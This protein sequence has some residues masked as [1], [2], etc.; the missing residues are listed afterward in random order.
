M[1]PIP[2]HLAIA[3]SSLLL[4]AATACGGSDAKSSTDKVVSASASSAAAGTTAAGVTAA[5]VTAAP[6]ATVT[7][8]AISVAVIPA[9]V[10]A[11]RA[12]PTDPCDLLTAAIAS[13]ALGVAVGNKITQSGKGNTTCG[14][15][16]AD[17]TAQGFVSLTLYGVTG[18]EVVLDAAAAQF[19]DAESVDGVGDAARLSMRSQAIGVLTGSTVFAV[20]LFPQKAD[21]QLVPITKDQLI[22]VARAVLA[23]Q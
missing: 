11:P 8:P 22:A 14:Y 4:I 5:G 21:G 13:Q 20:G 6:A 12:T 17:P 1:L 19:P 2:K 9:T 16:P 10:S 7:V 23:G 18:S 3:C 15:R